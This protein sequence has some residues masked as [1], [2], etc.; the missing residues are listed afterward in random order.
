MTENLENIT[1][2]LIEKYIYILE[3]KGEPDEAYKYLAINTFQ[4][5]W[6]LEAEDFY[7]MFREAF[8]KFDNL[9]YQNSWGFIDKAAKTFP[10]EVREMF[11]TL[12]D[13]TVDISQRITLFQSK[14]EQLLPK[15]KTALGTDKLKAQQDER[16]I[17]VYLAFRFPEKYTLYKADYYK[18]FCKELNIQPKKSGE[19]FLHLQDLATQIIQ[20][21]LLDESFIKT[22]RKYYPKPDWND[23]Y[24]MFQNIVYVTNRKDFRMM[25]L[26]EIIKNFDR[27]QLEDYYLFLDE[28]IAKF[29]LQEDDSKLVFN[30]N[31]KGKFIVFT[32]GQRYIWRVGTLK[33]KESIY[34]VISNEVFITDY[35]SFKGSPKA[36][37][38]LSNDIVEIINHKKNILDTIQIELNRTQKSS[39]LIKNN[40][41]L[42]RMAFDI[43]FRNEILNQLDYQTTTE[44][45][46]ESIKSNKKN[47][48]QS[49]FVWCSWNWENIQYKKN[50]G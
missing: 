44:K 16:T 31:A 45:P 32:I 38:S 6:N 2:Q 18:N 39:H 11:R 3:K 30:Y 40:K 50:S 43:D 37:W 25:N 46:M 47:S 22:Y 1:S 34:A 17:S 20:E 29:Q 23:Q 41:E 28:I 19:C 48:T 13:E 9:L 35:S 8:S 36:Y 14:A 33:N 24:L 26:L 27:K 21:G 10:D 7:P 4:Q 12:Y 42:E 15:I 49:N 5:N